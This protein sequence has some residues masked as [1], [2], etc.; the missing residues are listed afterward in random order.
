MM[1][2]PWLLLSAGVALFAVGWLYHLPDMAAWDERAFLWLHRRLL[3]LQPFFRVLWILGTLWGIL[4]AAVLTAGA[5]G[6]RK[7]L[8][9]LVAYGV[10]VTIEVTIKKT[11]KRPRPFAALSGVRMAQPRAPIDPSFPSGDA[12]RIWLIALA[13]MA[14]LPPLWGWL[15]FAVAVLV[16]LG[17]IA[18]GVHH[19]LDVIAGTGLGMLAA[20]LALGLGAWL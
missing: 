2:P 4:G 8:A 5:L 12:L 20:A 13:L 15:L 14:W 18:L 6:W 9:L 16:S 1:I 7:G 10:V 11:V 17:R 3:P 19:P